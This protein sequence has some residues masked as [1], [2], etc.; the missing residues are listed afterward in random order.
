MKRSPPMKLRRPPRRWSRCSSFFFVA[1]VAGCKADPPADPTVVATLVRLPS[2]NIYG[3]P[4]RPLVV[5]DI[6]TP[7]AAEAAGAAH[8]AWSDVRLERAEQGAM[9]GSR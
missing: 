3:R 7:T 1:A 9:G 5:I 8:H 2:R 4:A 6:R